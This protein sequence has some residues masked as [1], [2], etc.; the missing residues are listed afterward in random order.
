MAIGSPTGTARRCGSSPSSASLINSGWQ[1]A[2]G[3]LEDLNEPEG[4]RPRC[5]EGGFLVATNGDCRIRRHT[6]DG[7]MVVA[8]TGF[9]AVAGGTPGT[10]TAGPPRPRTWRLPPPTSRRRQTAA[11]CSTLE[12]DRVRRVA[13]DGTISLHCYATY[14]AHLL[15]PRLPPARAHRPRADARRRRADRPLPAGAALRHELRAAR[16]PSHR[17]S[18][19]AQQPPL[20]TTRP[21]LALGGKKTQKAGKI[22][23][24]V[25]SA[26]TEGLFAS[27]SGSVSVPG[28]ARV[29]KLKS[30]HEPLVAG[31]TKATLKLKGAEERPRTRSRTRSAG[32]TRSRRTSSSPPATPPGNLTTGKRTVKLKR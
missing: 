12:G 16:H 20:D 14:L 9:C 32:R 18:I 23:S 6:A 21:G 15:Q 24:V 2:P 13:P 1:Q 10:A 3:A 17:R 30:I 29:Y 7:M 8:G 11:S 4:D 5:R 25:V 19:P 27:A 22:V 31:G 28:A 26:T